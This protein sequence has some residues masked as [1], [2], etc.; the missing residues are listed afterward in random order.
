[1]LLFV[2]VACVCKRDRRGRPARPEALTDA[3]GPYLRLVQMVLMADEAAEGAVGKFLHALPPEVAAQVI[4]T[5]DEEVPP[6]P[7]GRYDWIRFWL[8]RRHVFR[9]PTWLAIQSDGDG[10][11]RE[12][13]RQLIPCPTPMTDP[14]TK[15]RIREHLDRYYW[16]ELWWGVDPAPG[17][18]R[19]R[20]AH[21]LMVR[22]SI[23]RRQWPSL[24]G[25][26]VD[27]FDRRLDLLL[28]IHAGM[29]IVERAWPLYDHW[30]HLPVADL[31]M[32][33]P[34]EVIASEGIAGLQQVQQL[35]WQA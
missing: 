27:E 21:A 22:W 30:V 25:V 33:R 29:Q 34:I 11:S 6:R 9:P 16:A 14:A 19:L 24:L 8:A 28:M 7:L 15:T 4:G 26:T 5:L 18:V 35:I 10:W 17:I 31:G 20:Q 13:G 3:L 23:P 2:D 1:M 12:N 32:R